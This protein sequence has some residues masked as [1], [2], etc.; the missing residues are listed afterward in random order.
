MSFLS[1]LVRMLVVAAVTVG[2][3]AIVPRWW[4]GRDADAFLARTSPEQVAL[5]REVARWVTTEGVDASSF[6]TGSAR[7]DGE[8]AMGTY[9]MAALGLGQVV[10]ANPDL[11]DEL[12]PA[13]DMCIDQLLRPEIRRFGTAAWGDDGL[14][15]LEGGRG[16]A[17]LGYTALALSMDRLVRPDSPHARLN[18]RLVEA[19]A[20]RIDASPTLLFETYPQETYPIDNSA[21]V[22]AIGLYDR[23]TGADHGDLLR[24][25]SSRVRERVLDPRSGLLVQAVDQEGE[26]VDRPRASGTAFAAYF[27]SFSDRELSRT[28]YDALR[29]QRV[30]F[31]GFGGIRE[32]P[33]GEPH[34]PGDIDSGPVL[35][36]VGVSASGL[37]AAGARVHGDRDLFTALY[38]TVHL[39]GAPLDRGGRRRYVTGGPLGNAIMLAVL[40][41]GPG[42]APPGEE[43]PR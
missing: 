27:L 43:A 17:Y 3:T 35:L 31:M 9:Q 19:L 38:R 16:H 30:T 4:C 8:W 6:S 32:Y 15:D 10:L 2:V 22:A 28:L 23:A 29:N 14:A 34:G 25:W 33:V 18:D 7:F 11:R 5:A 20:R 21:G 24:R 42:A 26:P 12:L 36:G 1:R 40:T 37:A 13:L 39:F 41:A